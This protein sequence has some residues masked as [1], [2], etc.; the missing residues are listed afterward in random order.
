MLKSNK[1]QNEEKREVVTGESECRLFRDAVWRY[2]VKNNLT[3]ADL[4]KAGG[5]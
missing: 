1:S 4:A 5:V 2:L 3:Q